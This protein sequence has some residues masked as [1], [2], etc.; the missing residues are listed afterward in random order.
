MTIA[1]CKR[2]QHEH[3][4][5]CASPHHP[6]TLFDVR[7]ITSYHV[8][9]CSCCGFVFTLPRPTAEELNAFYTSSYFKRPTAGELGYENYRHAAEPNARR[10]WT[11]LNAYHNFGELSPKRLLDVGCATGGFMVEARA[12]GWECRG[13]ELSED[14]A[15]VA[16][17]EFG[18]DVVRGDLQSM[19]FGEERF[20]LV[21]MWHVLEHMIDPINSLEWVRRL[22]VPGGYLFIELPNWNSMGRVIKRDRW[23]QLKPPE[24]INFFTQ[25]SL[26][27]AAQQCG[28]QVVRC[29]THY[30]S[31]KDKAAVRRPSRTLYRLAW[32]VAAASCRIGR[33]GYLRLLARVPMNEPIG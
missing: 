4:P 30:P 28:F 3:C 12:V 13:L 16:R 7:T 26:R 22:I 2:L 27:Y 29:D 8:S 9:R 5:L 23:S 14:A 24:H 31:I 6:S 33:G 15:D 19:S 25:R 32:A 18:L 17:R 1:D 10:M 20:G 11:E 21:T